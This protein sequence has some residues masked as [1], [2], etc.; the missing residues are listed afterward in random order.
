MKRILILYFSGA[1]ST[2]KV[3]ELMRETLAA[4]CDV[5]LR[6]FEDAAEMDLNAFDGLILGTPV[7]HA[8]PSRIVTGYFKRMSPLRENIPAFIYNTRGLYS[9]N[10]NRILAKQVREKT[11][12]P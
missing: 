5:E 6:A 10:T 4:Q 11:S 9:C 7:Y 8:A 1:G 2:K 12:L 3:A